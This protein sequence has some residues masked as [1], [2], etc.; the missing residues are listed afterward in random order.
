MRM[1]SR[2]KPGAIPTIHYEQS[3]SE[4]KNCDVL[5]SPGDIAASPLRN[6]AV[7]TVTALIGH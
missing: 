3:R 7:D 2:K 4:I 1:G 6:Y 5:M